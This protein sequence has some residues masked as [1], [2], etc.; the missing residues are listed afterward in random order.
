MVYGGFRRLLFS[1]C[2]QLFA[3]KTAFRGEDQTDSHVNTVEGLE[4]ALR[5]KALN[6][7]LK[8]RASLGDRWV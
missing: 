5:S 3:R 4:T 1:N 8:L 6:V 2:S 7:E